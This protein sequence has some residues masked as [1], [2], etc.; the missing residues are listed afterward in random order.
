MRQMQIL[1]VS[2]LSGAG[3]SHVANILEDMGYYCVDNMPSQLLTK[4][5]EFCISASGKYERVALVTDIRG[6]ES[7]GALFESLEAI[8]AMGCDSK[9]IFLE[10]DTETIIRRY[11]ETRRPHP[12]M[13]GGEIIE[14]VILKEREKLKEVRQRADLVLDTTGKNGR[15]LKEL[16]SDFLGSAVASVPMSITVMSFGFK[17]GVPVEADLVFDV[18]FLPNPFYIDELREKTGLDKEV[19]D[20]VFSFA[21]TRTF[22][23]LLYPMFEFLIP[24]YTEEG[25]SLLTIAVGCTGGRHRSTAIAND[26]T[27]KIAKMGHNPVIFH[28][29]ISKV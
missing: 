29:D 2:G 22:L 26:I 1:I 10:A 24:H 23:E 21:P 12:L 5:A 4:F 9:I 11:K 28:R 8:A 15:I 3:K 25:K 13:S 20:Y 19:R 27:E 6:G 16:L 18:R 17:Y 7:F 14:N